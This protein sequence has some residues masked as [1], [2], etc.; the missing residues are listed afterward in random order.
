MALPAAERSSVT[1]EQP[2]LP[3]PV[4]CVGRHKKTSFTRMARHLPQFRDGGYSLDHV[5]RGRR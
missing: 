3:F 1:G 2:H 5:F 4:A